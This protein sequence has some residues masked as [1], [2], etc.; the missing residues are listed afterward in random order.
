M[1]FNLRGAPSKGRFVTEGTAQTHENSTGSLAWIC[2][3]LTGSQNLLTLEVVQNPGH[4]RDFHTQPEQEEMIYVLSGQLEQWIEDQKQILS[5][6]ESVYINKGVVHATFCH[7]D[8][9]VKY[10][11]V[12]GPCLEGVGFNV[13]DKSQEEP[14]K[15]MR[16]SKS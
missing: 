14:W 10:L 4:G 6:G 3:P 15:S 1:H 5:A 7:G 9:P 11:A 8:E 13:V 12:F 2:G 16:S